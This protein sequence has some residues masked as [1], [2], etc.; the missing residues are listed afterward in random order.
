LPE[1]VEHML[2][3]SGLLAHF[4]A[5][6]EGADRLENLKE[7]VNAAV[8]FVQEQDE[9]QNLDAFLTHA[10]LEA[11]EHQAGEG[12]DALQLMTVHSAKGLEFQA[13]FVTGLEEGLFPHE[14]SRNADDGLEEERRLMYVAITRARSR[15]YLS[16]AQQRMLHGQ[17]LPKVASRFFDEI[18]AGLVKWLTPRVAAGSMAQASPP[19]SWGKSSWETSIPKAQPRADQQGWR[20]G[21]NVVHAKFGQGVIV[22]AEGQG[23]DAR[24]QIN[25]GRQ[26]MKWLALEYAK[27]SAA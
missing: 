11:G 19:A 12:S 4:Q 6:K 20:I 22:D 8:L 16:F 2:A 14:Q 26:G 3:R 25:F 27:L 7:L 15:L 18:P 21:Q 13:V 10:A 1:I 9:Q 5:E 17:T 24:L 23:P